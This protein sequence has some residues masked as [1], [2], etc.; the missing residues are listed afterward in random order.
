MKRSDFYYDLP[1]ELIAQTPIA[2]RDQS[3]LLKMDRETGEISHH[4]F[5]EIAEYLQP[6]D[7][8]VLNDSRVIPARLVGVREDTGGAIEFVLLR[9]VQDDQWEVILK[10][11]RR[12]K[13]GVF[14]SFGEGRLRAEILGILDQGIRLVKF[15]Y[16]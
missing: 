1:E 13:P 14:F 11:G 2:N 10:P 12:A 16:S 5:S 4:R 15:H 3:R 6:G 9:R 7:V 8:L